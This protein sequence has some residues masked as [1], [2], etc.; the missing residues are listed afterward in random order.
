MEFQCATS[1]C[2]ATIFSASLKPV[3]LCLLMWLHFKKRTEFEWKQEKIN[4]EKFNSL[5]IMNAEKDEPFSVG[6]FFLFFFMLHNIPSLF[7]K[8][9]LQQLCNKKCQHHC[10]LTKV[11]TLPSYCICYACIYS[12]RNK[13]HHYESF[14]HNLE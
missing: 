3:K 11:I 1:S 5:D 14:W 7:S 2:L 10:V 6:A 9:T 4:P 8:A 13:Q 12:S